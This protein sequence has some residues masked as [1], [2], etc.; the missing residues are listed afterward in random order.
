LASSKFGDRVSKIDIY[1]GDNPRVAVIFWAVFVTKR[2]RAK[3][4]VPSQNIK[5]KPAGDSARLKTLLLAS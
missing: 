3:S 5:G 1:H 2:E 4:S